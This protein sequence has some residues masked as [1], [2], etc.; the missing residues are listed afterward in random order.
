LRATA[1]SCER[2]SDI[3]QAAVDDRDYKLTLLNLSRHS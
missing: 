2:P 3:F 1:Q